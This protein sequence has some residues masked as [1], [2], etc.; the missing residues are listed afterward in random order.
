MNSATSVFSGF[1]VF[2]ILG[3]MAKQRNTTVDKVAVD[4]AA[5]AFIAYP[6][7]VSHMPFYPPLFSFLFFAMLTNLGLST[8]IIFGQNLTTAV[9][10][11]FK[12][13]RKNESLTVV[14]CCLIGFLVGLVFCTVEGSRLVDLVDAGVSSWN[15]LLIAVLEVL[16]VS[17]VYGIDQIF[18]DIED[19]GM[20]LPSFL[21][22]Y[23][24]LCW[25]YVTP[26]ILSVILS[27]LNM[28]FAIGLIAI[29][30]ILIVAESLEKSR[31]VEKIVRVR[32]FS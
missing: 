9:L 5:L 18:D 10:D 15:C 27:G 24:R 13:L 20:K 12:T 14:C 29:G 8:M 25:K 6:D 28:P 7:A 4:G 16:L 30:L 11:H 3:F 26:G 31:L 19:M 17:W 23:W 2:S 32:T 22:Y 21:K 1:V